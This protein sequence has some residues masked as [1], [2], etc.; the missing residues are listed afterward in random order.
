ML[1]EKLTEEMLPIKRRKQN[2]EKKVYKE[3]L[4]TSVIFYLYI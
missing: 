2:R 3:S 1:A 4:T